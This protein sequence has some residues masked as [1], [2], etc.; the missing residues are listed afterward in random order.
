MTLTSI[1]NTMTEVVTLAVPML[2]VLLVFYWNISQII[3]TANNPE[4]R[5]QALP[6]LLW[7]IVAL[8]I[9]FSLGGLINIISNTLLGSSGSV[10][11]T[12]PVGSAG[13]PSVPLPGTGSTGVG[14]SGSAP[15]FPLTGGTGS[16]GVT[17]GS[18]GAEGSVP[19]RTTNAPLSPRSSPNGG[20]TVEP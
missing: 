17:G 10:S 18:H 2:L 5:K 1:I 8:V 16:T 4:K 9:I 3:F 11:N 12:L 7:S 15:T 19:G 14:S 13:S 20:S 6:R